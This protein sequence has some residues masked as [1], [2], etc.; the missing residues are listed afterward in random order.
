MFKDWRQ[1]LKKNILIFRDALACFSQAPEQ[2]ERF[3]RCR[4]AAD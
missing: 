4:P 2:L 1:K 3:L